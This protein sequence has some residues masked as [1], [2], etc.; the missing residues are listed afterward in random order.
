MFGTNPLRKQDLNSAKLSIQK[1][2]YTI[3]GE[4]PLSGSPAVF[5]RLAG[6]NLRCHFCDTEFESGIDNLKSVNEVLGEILEASPA[7]KL[8]VLT[9]GEPLRQNILSLCYMLQGE[10][11]HVQIE[12]AGTLWVPGLQ[13]L[14][15]PYPK[16]GVSIVVSPKTG[17]VVAEIEFHAVA[18]KYIINAA[19]DRAE[20]DGLP[21][22]GTQ[23]KIPI[24][25]RLARPFL[26][27]PQ[28]IFLS[29]C[30]MYDAEKNAAN[31]ALVTKLALRYGYRVSLQTHKLINVE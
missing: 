25:V 4:G 22:T 18:W 29:P 28:R 31:V 8:V 3:Q 30:D 12:T 21:L 10:N 23:S 6:C 9:G 11:F 20:E 14:I 7:C 27:K 17:K 5:V 24:K 1:I 19:D 26:W 2:F 15:Q 13:N 16:P